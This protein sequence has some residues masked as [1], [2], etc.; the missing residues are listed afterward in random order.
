MQTTV[1]IYDISL[2]SSEI[3]KYFETKFA[4]K[5]QTHILFS[6]TFFFS[7]IALFMT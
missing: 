7:K 1:Y 4:Q 3:E 5:F 2:N 6:G